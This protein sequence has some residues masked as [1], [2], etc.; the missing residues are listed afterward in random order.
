MFPPAIEFGSLARDFCPPA[1]RVL[2]GLVA[3]DA[4]VESRSEKAKR[5]GSWTSSGRRVPRL[6]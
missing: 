5:R 6:S 4:V 2:G 3:L 1:R